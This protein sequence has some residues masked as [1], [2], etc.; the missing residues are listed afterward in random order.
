MSHTKFVENQNKYVFYV[1]QSVSRNGAFHDTVLINMAQ[2][3]RL[4]MT[5]CVCNVEE[6][7]CGVHGR[8]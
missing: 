6:K 4:Q 1:T 7:R 5:I 2:S 8:F 3:D